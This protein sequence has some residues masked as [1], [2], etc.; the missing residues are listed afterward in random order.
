MPRAG[1]FAGV[2]YGVVGNVLITE[3]GAIRNG[4]G[5]PTV[6]VLERQAS[7]VV[8]GLGCITYGVQQ[9]DNLTLGMGVGLL[10]TAVLRAAT[11]CHDLLTCNQAPAP[12]IR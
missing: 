10:G 8:L 3:G 9:R 4:D 7:M 5:T 2:A 11:G 1:F 6:D 12:A